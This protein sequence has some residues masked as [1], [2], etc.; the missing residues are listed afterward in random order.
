MFNQKIEAVLEDL[1]LVSLHGQRYYDI[2]FRT[3][4]DKSLRKS[5]APFEEFYSDPEPGDRIVIHAIMGT[6]TKVEKA[7][8]HSSG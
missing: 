3:D 5:R 2:R 1:Q 7:D 4:T 6:I 8:Q